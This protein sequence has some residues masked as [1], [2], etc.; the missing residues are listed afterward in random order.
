[1]VVTALIKFK[2]TVMEASDIPESVTLTEINDAF[3]NEDT[4]DTNFPVL[5]CDI[6]SNGFT[7]EAEYCQHALNCKTN[8]KKRIICALCHEEK[9]AKYFKEHIRLHQG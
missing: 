9:I 5:I 7:D 8:G 1:M 2:K 4:F 3:S 6:C